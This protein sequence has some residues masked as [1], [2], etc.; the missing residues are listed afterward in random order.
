MH[1]F[2]T[3]LKKAFMATLCHSSLVVAKQS[4]HFAIIPM[5]AHWPI[6]CQHVMSS[7]QLHFM[8]LKVSLSHYTCI[9]SVAHIEKLLWQS[10][11]H[12]S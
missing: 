11:V 10:F 2:V 3:L 6:G 4:L 8:E 7:G 9:F 5:F 12:E 1:S